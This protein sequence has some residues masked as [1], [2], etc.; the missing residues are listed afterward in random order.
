MSRERAIEVADEL[1]A[2]VSALRRRMQSEGSSGEYT[3]S[4]LTVIANLAKH[5]P[6]TV[7]TLAAVENM[8][9]QSMG[10][11]VS[12]LETIG[13]V[14]GSPHPTDGRQ[15]LWSLTPGALEEYNAGRDARTNWLHSAVSSELS[16]RELDE[17]ARSIAALRRVL[18]R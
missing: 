10:A 2:V 6:A 14:T 7:T 1:R 4:Q 16:P 13:A 8:R 18:D 5:G 3:S 11:I 9:P 17:L 15:T 12:S